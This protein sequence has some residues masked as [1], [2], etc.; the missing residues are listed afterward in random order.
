MRIRFS[1]HTLR[2][3]RFG[4]IFIIFAVVILFPANTLCDHIPFEIRA[5]RCFLLGLKTELQEKIYLQ[6]DHEYY[7][8][9]DTIWFRAWQVSA[10]THMSPGFS[11]FL[12][13]EL[14]DRRDSVFRRVKI[15]Y[16]DSLFTGYLPLN[17]EMTQGEYFLRTYSYW[18]QNPGESFIPKKRIHVLN[19]LDS[20]VQTQLNYLTED[21]NTYVIVGF[22]DSRGG[23]YA[24]TG[25]EY[26]LN[27]QVRYV[28]TNEN[29][30]VRIKTDASGY[31]PNLRVKFKNGLPFSFERNL[32]L[33]KPED[34]FEVQFFPEGGHLLSGNRQTI[35]FK[36]TGRNGLSREV[37]LQIYNDKDEWICHSASIHKG[38]GKFELSVQ[39]GHH[40]YV[41]A[42]VSGY[43]EKRV[44]LPV[45]VD[46][47]MGM[48]IQL[49][50]SL[51]HYAVCCGD[52]T[53][54]PDH[55]YL[56]AHSR[57]V[58]VPELCLPLNTK[59]RGTMGLSGIQEGILELVLA[60]TTGKV[61]SRR[62][63][64]VRNK[65]RVELMLTTDKSR[66]VMYDEVRVDLQLKSADS[67]GL[68]GSFAVSVTDDSQYGRDSLVDHIRSH[69]LLTS[70]LKGYVEDPAWY[71]NLVDRHKDQCL[72]LLMLTQG[73]SRFDVEDILHEKYTKTSWPLELGQSISGRVKNV[74]NKKGRKDHSVLTLLGSDGLLEM[75]SPDSTGRFVIGGLVFPEHTRFVLQGRN[76][77]GKN[78]V[79][80]SVDQERF[81]KPAIFIPYDHYTLAEDDRLYEK[82]TKEYYYE[83]GIK[84]YVLDE[85]VIRKRTPD[86]QRDYYN[87]MSDRILDSVRLASLANADLRTILQEFPGVYM[88]INNKTFTRMNKPVSVILNNL[89][90]NDMEA[91]FERLESLRGTDLLRVNLIER[92]AALTL[93][94]SENGAIV[95]TTRSGYISPKRSPSNMAVFTLLGY[96]QE[97]EFYRPRYDVD[98]VRLQLAGVADKRK[99]IYWN[100]QIQTGADGHA[101]FFFTLPDSRG[102]YSVVLEGIL[103]DGTVCRAHKPVF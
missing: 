43:P 72:D 64:F 103:K 88:D 85:V 18:M 69:L 42:S 81:M 5:L 55:L 60:D 101:F 9:G 3:L 54:I 6:T 70:D 73:W 102:S 68:A 90:V 35:A 71:F 22:A 87:N 38:M 53:E 37:S 89:V 57:G 11:R 10:A 41:R 21:G 40:Y 56:L 23:K 46:Y 82:N 16:R 20:R 65:E 74:W 30:E 33:L 98:S 15:P 24:K 92:M 39:A 63:C 49:T 75:V 95:I 27:G 29:G 86:L 59:K 78:R 51:I 52:R 79:E 62:L 12:Y 31:N 61:Y 34:D 67:V 45:P 8:A 84:N 93:Y 7:E 91:E 48:S 4:R 28:N 26:E 2:L 83:N 32:P 13:V 94:G 47:G 97:A 17:K 36:A 80:V 14:I 96:Q 1:Y 66:Y 50:D 76:D 77:K 25:I 19:P 99:T 44:E 100:P 58:P